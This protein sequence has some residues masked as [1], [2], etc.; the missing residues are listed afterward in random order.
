MSEQD[1]SFARIAP[2]FVVPEVVR[3]AEYYRDV[4]GFTIAGYFG[5]QPPVFAIVR[6]GG[7]EI[8]FGRAD[9]GSA[10]ANRAQ[11]AEGLDAYVWVSDVD[12]LDAEFRSRG[13]DIILGPCDQPWDMREIW[14]RDP[15]GFVIAFGA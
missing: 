7:A 5:G 6:R 8:H 1:V 3:A 12:R 2:Q 14:V 15:N 9:A 11:R 4:F 13:V 10:G